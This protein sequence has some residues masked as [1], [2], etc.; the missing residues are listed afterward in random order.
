MKALCIVGLA[1]L[2]GL[3]Q[4]GASKPAT[5]REL[6][7]FTGPVKS[8]LL[9][10]SLISSSDGGRRTGSP[11]RQ[12]ADVY[13]KTGRLLQHSAYLGRCG[14]DEIRAEYSYAADGSRTRK[15]RGIQGSGGSSPGFTDGSSTAEDTRQ[16]REIF[17]YDSSRRITE[18][19]TV[20]AN[21]KVKYK[22]RYNYNAQGR[23][24]EIAEY[25]DDGR[26]PARR[27][28][29]YEGDSQVPFEFIYYGHDGQAY[30]KTTYTDYEFNS[31]GD[32]VK[33]KETDQRSNRK[34][35]SWTLRK[36][37]YYPSS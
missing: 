9:E 7:G 33:R 32:W 12:T 19:T 15:T 8:V 13:D 11:C 31:Q 27:A 24:I 6:D 20:Q 21:G 10:S 35:V 26:G 22:S 28:Y 37:E 29:R 17:T 23:M 5:D 18:A 30:S 25:G 34:Y 2:T 3:I 1:L 14:S 4:G 16:H 36:I